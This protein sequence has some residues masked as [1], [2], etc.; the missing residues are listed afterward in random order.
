MTERK[1]V[2]CLV[3]IMAGVSLIVGGIAIVMLYHVAI[4]QTRERLVETAES[5]ARL[6]E[7]VARFDADYSNDYPEG[8]EAATLSQI[9]DA[10]DHYKGFGES[11]EFTLARREGNEIVFLLRHRH[12]DL[13][14]PQP[15]PFDSELAEPI[16]RA[17]AGQSGTLI[18]LDYRGAVVIAAYEPVK[19]LS[20][21]I[22]AK[23]DMAEVRAPFVRAALA[24][25]AAATVVIVTGS[26]LFVRVT[27]PMIVRLQEL[28]DTAQ[29]E[30]AERKQAET[31]LHE[32]TERMRA[33]LSTAADAIITIDQCGIISGLNSATERM[34]GYT[35]QE[36]VG[37]NVG[38]L[39]PQPYRGEHDGYIRRYLETGEARIIGIGRE[40]I[41]KRK[42]SSTFPA[43]LAVSEVDDL[44][45]LTGMVRDI[46]DRKELEKQVLEIAA[47]EDRRI[48][49]ELHD[50]TQQ[51]L[52]GLGLLAQSV[53]EM[54]VGAK[55]SE[56]RLFENPAFSE[57]TDMAARVAQ[58]ISETANHVHLLSRGLVPVEVDAEGLRAALSRLA[59]NTGELHAV[60]CG[61]HCQGPVELADNFVATHLYR[62]AQEAVNNALTHSR[63]KRIDI[64][65]AKSNENII[66]KVLDNGIGIGDTHASGPGL[67]LRIMSYRAGLIGATLQIGHGQQGGTLVSCTVS[68]SRAGDNDSSKASGR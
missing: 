47:E 35:K 28:Y 33:I 8:S 63:T 42:D 64:S 9:V 52:T 7:A 30:L 39:M 38:I 44:G 66:M 27:N 3:L 29:Q 50:N 24:G 23:I 32:S 6:I 19:E 14:D 31:Q 46:S 59:S 45:L 1:R 4:E 67:G 55:K 13:A 60:R 43:D 58:G 62:I 48:G 51:Q 34:F 57:A 37:Q 49:H 53:A 2:V 16:R 12:H 22:V 15:V 54:L 25:L 21:G 5:Q 56:P 68:R 11:G 17:L 65:L 61:F 41:G 20:L 26:L 10:H 18:G 40:V 36:L